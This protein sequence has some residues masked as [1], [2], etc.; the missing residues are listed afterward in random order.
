MKKKKYS[1]TK[2]IIVLIHKSIRK[3]QIK[4]II[5]NRI[6]NKQNENRAD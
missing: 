3:I 4:F 6:R 2:R 5:T 1:K